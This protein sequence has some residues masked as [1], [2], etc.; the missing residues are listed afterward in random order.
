MP[1]SLLVSRVSHII[2][3]NFWVVRREKESIRDG[4]ESKGAFNVIYS[5]FFSRAKG[6]VTFSSPFCRGLV[7]LEGPRCQW[8][9]VGSTV[10]RNYY[11]R[12]KDPSPESL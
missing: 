7:S 1:A 5:I 10:L 11:A 12:T 9:A 6:D 4:N 3:T 8:S 2:A